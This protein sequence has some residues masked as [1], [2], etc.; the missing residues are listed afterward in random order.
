MS[1]DKKKVTAPLSYDPGKGRPKEYLAYLNWQEMEAL[2]RINGNNMERGPMGLPSFPPDWGGSANSTGNWTGSGTNTNVG[3]T[4]G[5]SSDSG[6]LGASTGSTGTTTSSTSSAPNAAAAAAYANAEAERSS[7]EAAKQAAEVKAATEAAR[8]AA[9]SQDAA[10]GGIGSISIG[11]QQ[12]PV[13]IG[14]GQVFGTLSQMASQSYGLAVADP[15]SV[16]PPST[17]T[18]PIPRMNPLN[19]PSK[20]IQQERD[21]FSGVNP[22]A[23]SKIVRLQEEFGSPLTITSGVRSPSENVK[24]GGAKKSQHIHGNAID[25]AIPGASAA[26]TASLINMASGVGFSGIGG[27]RPGKIHVDV[28]GQRVWGPSYGGASISNLPKTMQSALKSHMAGTTPKIKINYAELERNPSATAEIELADTE[29]SYNPGML[30][31]P[32]ATAGISALMRLS[33]GAGG[34]NLPSIPEATQAQK[35][36][37]A[38][39]KKVMPESAYQAMVNKGVAEAM[40]GVSLADQFSTGIGALKQALGP[41]QT[42]VAA[43]TPTMPSLEPNV[44]TGV[45]AGV[46]KSKYGYPTKPDGTPYTAEDIANLPPEVQSEYMNKLRFARQTDEPYPL[47]SDQ[48]EKARV[49]GIIGRAT[50]SNP[51]AR[52]FVRGV[53]LVGEGIGMLPG[54]VGEAGEEIAYGSNQI[55]D[56]GES[57]ANYERANPLRQQQMAEM[58]GQTTTPG[59]GTTF[60]GGIPSVEPGNKGNQ[61]MAFNDTF[62]YPED[63]TEPRVQARR[64]RKTGARDQYDLWDRGIDIPSP[65]DPDYNDY[66]EYLALRG[67]S[68]EV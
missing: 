46:I 9:L 23:L 7:D 37:L 53:N 15:V 56:P 20:F 48:T 12:Q 51:L 39:A 4:T 38:F 27:Y 35:S 25:I 34:I 30:S 19:D 5:G 40:S 44:S 10:R 1:K 17:E 36:A 18:A 11:P 49:A 47:T 63:E 66:Q 16:S 54:A 68:A 2:K 6:S 3:G 33:S 13:Q 41:A 29:E 8:N 65:G 52:A 58:A 45:E 26:E 61:F 14:G 24:R 60:T 57:V 21:V 22:T 55:M 42:Q 28:G 62:T 50:I 43:S 59:Y 32:I 31:D 64:R 67:D